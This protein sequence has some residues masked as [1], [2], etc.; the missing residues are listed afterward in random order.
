ME[1]VRERLLGWVL[2]FLSSRGLDEGVM[3]MA[4]VLGWVCMAG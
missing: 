2:L 3:E 4:C 1:G